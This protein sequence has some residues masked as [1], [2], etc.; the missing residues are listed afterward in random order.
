MIK[1][2]EFLK[3]MIKDRMGGNLVNSHLTIWTHDPHGALNHYM[4]LEHG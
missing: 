3:E 1:S 4:K 2:K